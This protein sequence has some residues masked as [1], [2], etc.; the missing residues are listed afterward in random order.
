M[1]MIDLTHKL[2]NKMPV[3]PGDPPVKIGE[4]KNHHMDE[5]SLYKFQGNMHMGT[6]LDAP[7]HFQKGG[8]KISDLK[9]NELIQKARIIDVDSKKIK[10]KHLKFLN[11]EKVIIF[12]TGWSS[13]WGKDEYFIKNPYLS[14]K[15]ANYLVELCVKG[16][17]IDA[18]S[19]DPFGDTS[20]HK[21][22]LSH[23]IWILENLTNLDKIYHDQF[24]I[25]IIPLLLET[26]SSPVRAFADL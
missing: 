19:V 25:Y 3:Y 6:H 20:N 4:I 24:K 2:Y 10:V 16:I 5:Y 17:G 7:Y 13:K 9:L 18:P 14:S 11:D 23:D 22:L 21:T 26:E 1:R 15:C 8:R 12:R